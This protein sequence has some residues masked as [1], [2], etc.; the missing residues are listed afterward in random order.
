MKKLTG[1]SYY[2]RDNC[3]S[4]GKKD[5]ELVIK[6][7]PTPLGEEYIKEKKPQ[8]YYPVD[9]FLCKDCNLL[10]LLDVVDPERLYRDYFY[11]T[12]LSLGL[13][14]HF[15][16]YAES[17]IN[18]LRIPEK[19]FFLDI[20][21]NDG[22]LL[23]SLKKRGMHI[24][25]V[26]PATEIAKK[27]T[28]SGLETIPDFFTLELASKIKKGHGKASVITSNNLLANIDNLDELIEGVKNLLT[29][30]GVYIVEAAYSLDVIQNTIIDNIYHEHLSYFSA[31]SFKNFFNSHGMELIDIERTHM[32]GGSLR[33]FAQ[34]KKG[35]RRKSASVEELITLEKSFGLYGS[36]IYKKFDERVHNEKKR[37]VSILKKFKS[38]KKT[39]AGYGASVGATVLL[40]N[41]GIGKDIDFIVDDYKPKQHLYSPGFHIPTFPSEEIY[42]KKPDCIVNLAW[43][44]AESIINK[45]K[46]Y[47]NNG[48]E[49]ITPFSKVGE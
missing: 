28:E 2:R 27:A 26:D 13:V 34:L 49:F 14:N 44:Y 10:Q 18:K 42:I 33:A 3:R 11:V 47:K 19:S 35:L 48:G 39:I 45:H 24:L 22:V 37:L 23:T 16:D 5:L 1:K 41:L 31:N 20:G 4:C 40:H 43:R 8:E 9:V 12:S 29:D 17:V 36:E 38:E 21:S 15:D 6:N 46:A 7:E 25:G 32:K 30:D